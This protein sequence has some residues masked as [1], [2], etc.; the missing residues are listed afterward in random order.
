MRGRSRWKILTYTRCRIV[1][2]L[3]P[4]DRLREGCMTMQGVA[5]ANICV[6]FSF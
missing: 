2:P 1:K 4:M 5:P 6:N 3:I